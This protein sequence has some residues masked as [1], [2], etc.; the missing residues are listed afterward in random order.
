MKEKNKEKRMSCVKEI[1]C[2]ICGE[3]CVMVRKKDQL[4]SSE[5]Y[6][7]T[8]ILSSD[9]NYERGDVLAYGRGGIAILSRPVFFEK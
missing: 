4:D 7:G 3:D 8:E 5:F 9:L 6:G 2:Y 1:P